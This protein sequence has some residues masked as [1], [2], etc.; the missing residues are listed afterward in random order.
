MQNIRKGLLLLLQKV[1]SRSLGETLEQ[2]FLDVG[3]KMYEPY[4]VLHCSDREDFCKVLQVCKPN[5]AAAFHEEGQLEL[6][7]IYYGVSGTGMWPT[8][9]Q[10]FSSVY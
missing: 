1:V 4:Y 9:Y 5:L 8:T 10:I 7:Q 6:L 3:T 2:R